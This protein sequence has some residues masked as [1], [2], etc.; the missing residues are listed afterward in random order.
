MRCHFERTD[1]GPVIAE[2]CTVDTAWFHRGKW[3]PQILGGCAFRHVTLRGNFTGA[4][5]IRWWPFTDVTPRHPA[6]ADHPFVSANAAFYRGVDWALDISEA[7]FSDFE[8]R[9]SDIPAR[10]IRR[11]PATQAIVTR[12]MLLDRRWAKLKLPEPSIAITLETFLRTG[13][14]DTVIVAG[15]RSRSFEAELATLDLPRS[16]RIAELG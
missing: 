6:P 4:L 11:D 12:N 15:K 14:G 1:L 16:E 7:A 3:G 13:I 5:S 2:D 8:L 9:F 10:L